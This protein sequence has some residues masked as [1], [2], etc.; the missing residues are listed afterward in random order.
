MRIMEPTKAEWV[1]IHVLLTE[2]IPVY[3]MIIHIGHV[4]GRD[5]S[6]HELMLPHM[7]ALYDKAC[8]A[9]NIENVLKNLT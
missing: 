1:I 2:K 9:L 3:Q 4:D 7:Q 8:E 6:A 5:V